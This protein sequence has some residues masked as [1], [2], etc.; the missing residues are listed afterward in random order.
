MS[1]PGFQSLTAAWLFLLLLPVIL[2]YFLKLKRQR[3]R[4]SSLALWQQVMEDPR[5]NSPFRRFK[6]N[7]LLWLQLLLLTLLVLAA[8]QPYLRAGGEAAQRH[9][10]LVD[11]SASMAADGPDG[12]SRLAAAKARVRRLIDGMTT[13][14]EVALIAFSDGAERLTGFTS[15]KSVLRR[16]LERL[17]VR[18]VPSE[19]EP[20]LRTARVI[21]RSQGFDRAVL[22]SDGNFPKKTDFKLPFRI[23]YLRLPPGGPNVGITALRAKREGTSWAIFARLAASEDGGGDAEVTLR[24]QD[25][26]VDTTSVTLSGGGSERILFRIDPSDATDVTVRVDPPSDDAM[27][28][29]DVAHLH[30]PKPRPVRVWAPK[31][32]TT[33]RKALA[34]MSSVALHPSSDADTPDAYDLVITDKPGSAPDAPVRLTVGV[35][36]SPLQELVTVTDGGTRV[37]DW[38]RSSPLLRHIRLAQV[39]ILDRPKT[40]AKT[41]R[42]SFEAR[43]YRVLAE[44]EHGPLIVAKKEDGRRHFALLFHTDRSTLPYRVGFPILVRNAVGIASRV[45]GLDQIQADRTGTL[46]PISVEAN[47]TY[48]VEGPAGHTAEATATSDG[49][50]DAVA[51]PKVGRYRI[52]A[53]G[54]LRARRS[55]SLLSSRETKLAS[56]E[57]IEFDEQTTEEASDET[58]AVD[59]ALWPYV[60]LA[61]L[62][63][64][65]VEW[66][67]FHRRPG[68]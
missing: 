37:V 40:D 31:T 7:L 21:G 57:S 34:A 29:D 55:A 41:T 42:S 4:I 53:D 68:R 64:L 50:L 8:M 9:A 63:V 49:R 33:Y 1:W 5:V 52:S 18:E 6:R 44:G 11:R 23:R 60:A 14:E 17:P 61:A 54:D 59:R 13:Q 20:A 48:R 15:D 27:G 32:L 25:K 36:P 28:S 51:A 62:A 10:I 35:V 65:L 22:L 58:V 16:A 43:G 38:R 24:R 2:F 56:V 66:W 3:V 39:V 30:L 12:R 26:T 67:F 47:R 19:L 45:A 46:P